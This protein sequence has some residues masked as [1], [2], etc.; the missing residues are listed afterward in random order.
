[1]E[2][3]APGDLGTT[4]SGKGWDG[5]DADH[6]SSLPN[7]LGAGDV[8]DHGFDQRH[9]DV[10]VHPGEQPYQG[11]RGWRHLTA[12]D[13]QPGDAAASPGHGRPESGSSDVYEGPQRC[14][15]LLGDRRLAHRGSGRQHGPRVAAKENQNPQAARGTETAADQPVGRIQGRGY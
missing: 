3:N 2:R 6:Q 1:M 8:S 15:V 12:S 11:L 5:I 7:A 10:D 9:A 13:H 4:D 14:R